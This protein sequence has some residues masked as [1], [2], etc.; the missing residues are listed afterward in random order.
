MRAQDN[1][2]SATILEFD[3]KAP[4]FNGEVKYK[5]LAST[6]AAIRNNQDPM[7]QRFGEW[8]YISEGD[9]TFYVTG[10]RNT[11]GIMVAQDGKVVTT[12]NGPNVPFGA[13]MTGMDKQL[14]PTVA[15]D[16]E[17][18]DG[19]YLDAQPVRTSV[20]ASQAALVPV[21]M[22]RQ[23]KWAFAASGRWSP[24]T[25]FTARKGPRVQGSIS[26]AEHM[27]PLYDGCVQLGCAAGS[28]ACVH[29]A[30]QDHKQ[31]VRHMLN[32]PSP[33]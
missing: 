5:F 30:G 24:S 3:I 22:Y 29:T 14:M 26:R 2:T 32:H 17:T 20:A 10:S 19:I 28:G 12:V 21:H 1:P 11:F 31:L 15:K 4:G 16:P 25:Q 27:C 7:D 18:L 8:T 33:Q 23:R 9:V 6:P 13:Q